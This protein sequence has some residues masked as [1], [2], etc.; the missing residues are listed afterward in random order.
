[1]LKE[2]FPAYYLERFVDW[3]AGECSFDSGEF[4][5]L[6]LWLE[7]HVEKEQPETATGRRIIY[8]TYYAPEDALL[9][10]ARDVTFNNLLRIEAQIGGKGR[11]LGLPTGYIVFQEVP[12]AFFM[13]AIRDHAQ[14]VHDPAGSRPPAVRCGKAQEPDLPANLNLYPEKCTR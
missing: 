4:R 9:M 12:C 1:M 11:V 14:L 5:E 10:E 3:E 13:K 2:F 6:L 7:E 8:E